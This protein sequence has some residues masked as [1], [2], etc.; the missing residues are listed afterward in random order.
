MASVAPPGRAI[1]PLE[2]V[3]SADSGLQVPGRPRGVISVEP[4]ASG[5][6]VAVIRKAHGRLVRCY[7]AALR[8]R[9]ALEGRVRYQLQVSAAGAVE[10]AEVTPEDEVPG[11]VARCL[12][13]VL[14]AL[15]F[16]PSLASRRLT[17][18]LRLTP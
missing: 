1:P 12:E 15:R 5:E 11:V 2:G 17:G 13:G 7:A 16:Q 18:H 9:P 14:W 10:L 4:A 3:C 8:Q 6:E